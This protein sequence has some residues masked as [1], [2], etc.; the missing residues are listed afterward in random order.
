MRGVVFYDNALDDDGVVVTSISGGSLQGCHPDALID[1]CPFNTWGPL[2]HDSGETQVK[3]DLGSEQRIVGFGIINHNFYV[4]SL[5][6]VA[7]GGNNDG[8]SSYTLVTT[9]SGLGTIDHDPCT[10]KIC[11]AATYRYWRF[12]IAQSTY[13]NYLGGLFLARQSGEF[14]ET[15]DAPF[16]EDQRDQIVSAVTEGG[17]E[18]RQVRG[19]PFYTK[20]LRWK[21]TTESMALQA[22]EMWLKQHGRSRAFLYAAHDKD[23]PTGYDNYI[24]E[25]LR[26][27]GISVQGL[28][29][30]SRHSVLMTLV[31]LLRIDH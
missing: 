3:I 27:A 15:P 9:L 14:E 30:G 22:Q 20:A 31:G 13:A 17:Y 5:P 23:Q 25:V 28:S 16:E 19:E 12:N 24:P 4:A 29:P 6:Y 2:P 10:A 18:R 26:F 7:A 1:G 21:G 11:D 8:G